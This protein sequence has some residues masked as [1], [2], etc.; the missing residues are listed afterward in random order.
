[1]VVAKEPMF[2]KER[3]DQI[4]AILKKEKKLLVQELSERLSVSA[5]TVRNDLRELEEK[6]LL[7][8]THGGAIPSSNTGFEEDSSR[9]EAKNIL[10]KKAIAKAAAKY[11]QNGDTIAIDTGTT[12]LAFAYELVDKKNLT[13]VT[14]DLK[15]ALFLEENTDATVLLLGGMVRRGYHCNIGPLAEQAL[16]QLYVDKCFM[17]TNGATAQRGLTTPN[18]DQASVKRMI[19]K[20]SN[21]VIVICDGEKIGRNALV[22]FSPVSDIHLLITDTGADPQSLNAI[23]ESD[24]EIQC[25]DIETQKGRNVT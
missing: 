15:I 22:S 17:A 10:Q 12:A 25:V 5:V 7:I 9:K 3:H 4:L 6:G 11:V 14:S 2:A 16:N 21:Q 24:V 18:V 8:R 23:A 19:I 20:H 1:M 13:V